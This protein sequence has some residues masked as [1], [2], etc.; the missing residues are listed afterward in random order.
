MGIRSLKTASISTGVKR[1]KVWD[2]SAV[3]LLGAYESIATVNVSSSQST[4][5]FS[6]IPSTY[7][8]LQIRYL[9]R[10]SRTDYTIATMFI[11][12]NNDSSSSYAGHATYGNGSAVYSYG[13]GSQTFGYSGAVVGA[14]ATANTFSGGIID[15]LDYTNTNKN[16]TTRTFTGVNINSSSGDE[17]GLQSG[18]WVN[19]AAVNRIDLT[20]ESSAN[21]NQYTTFALYGIKG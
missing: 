1:S 12:L 8:H 10:C 9:A 19:T 7:K 15:I 2:Q 14:N 17:V 11:R 18:L 21:F 16:T 20:L 6:S 4:I 13:N 3:V 5:T